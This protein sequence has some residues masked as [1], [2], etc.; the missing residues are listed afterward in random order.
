[1]RYLG[2]KSKIADEIL[3]VILK[4]AKPDQYYVEPFV[5]SAA[6]IQRVPNTFRRIGAD[7]NPYL[8]A[9]LI[10][11]RDGWEPPSTV[12]EEEYN[13]IKRNMSAYPKE[14]VGFVGFACAFGGAFFTT[15]ARHNKGSAGKEQPYARNGHDALM[16][17]APLYRGIEFR[18]TSY[19]S[20]EVPE[21]A[22]VYCDPPY[23]KTSGYAYSVNNFTEFWNWCGHLIDTG[24]KVFVSGY[25]QPVGWDVVWEKKMICMVTNQDLDKKDDLGRKVSLKRDRTEKL[26]TRQPK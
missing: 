21:D 19:A 11:V 9:L 6:V 4:D 25:S 14:L 8:I 7:K 3:E 13:E 10:A 16:R 23:E 24:R 17:D 18:C 1:V 5:G 26:F 2:N 15:F 20:L 12:T 22:I